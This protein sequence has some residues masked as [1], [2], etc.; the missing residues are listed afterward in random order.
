MIQTISRTM[1]R[2]WKCQTCGA[3][4]PANVAHGKPTCQD[5]YPIL[6]QVDLEGVAMATD[7]RLTNQ[8]TTPREEHGE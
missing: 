8:S 1:F 3:E 7:P 6:E 2:D 5:P 4:I